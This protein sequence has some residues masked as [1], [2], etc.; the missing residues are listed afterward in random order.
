MEMYEQSFYLAAVNHGREFELI[1]KHRDTFRVHSVFTHAINLVA[2]SEFL[3]V[4]PLARGCG[5][6]AATVAVSGDFS[7]LTLGVSI[8]DTVIAPTSSSLRLGKKAVIDFSDSRRWSSP[9]EAVNCLHLIKE[10]NLVVLE[11]ALASKHRD[12]AFDVSGGI[13]EEIRTSL[14]END[15]KGLDS[16]L[17]GI[18]GFGPG[19][20]PSGDDLVL[21][22]SLTRSVF[23]VPGR[24]R[25]G[26]WEACVRKNLG[27]TSDLSAFF[28]KRA[29]EGCA[30][31]TVERAL[32]CVLTGKPGEARDAVA[33]LL[34][35]G[36]TSGYDI[37]LGIYLALD[38]QRRYGW[39]SRGW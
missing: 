18:I 26:I 12:L 23:R 7:F 28:I 35:V 19:L 3:T 8:D 16:A 37:G 24:D 10:E 4:L 32:F 36:A 29:L 13:I 34:S 27:R 1:F 33:R 25:D 17:A 21:G 39:C 14:L 15:A 6:D 11:Q 5:R 9:L 30:H 22:M 38:W 2:G 31:E 20:T